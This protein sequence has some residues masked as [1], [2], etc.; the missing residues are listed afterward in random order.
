MKKIIVILL[1][2]FSAVVFSACIEF[3]FVT[4]HEVDQG[5]LKNN[6]SHNIYIQLFYFYDYNNN[7]D[8]IYYD[9]GF[10]VNKN[11]T[12]DGAPTHSS[13]SNT[14]EKIVFVDT[15][16]RK[17]LRTISAAEYF[18][19]L[20]FDDV[21]KKKNQDGGETIYFNYH[22]IITDQFLQW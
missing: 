15:D 19:I 7:K 2:F 1:L 21:V 17:I 13:Y 4:D 9:S 8:K 5:F 12:D 22:F 6:S 16:S 20:E 10:T 11:Q 3:L 14:L 18:K